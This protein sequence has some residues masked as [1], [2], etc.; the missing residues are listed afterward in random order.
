LIDRHIG[1]LEICGDNFRLKPIKLQTVRPF[2]MDEIVLSAEEGAD[3]N[4]GE[5]AIIETLGK[6]VEEMIASVVLPRRGK[7]RRS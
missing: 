3:P 1:L 5:Q 7:G 4:D 2:V 6:K